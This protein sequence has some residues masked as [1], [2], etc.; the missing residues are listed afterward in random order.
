M[1]EKRMKA[2]FTLLGL[3]LVATAYWFGPA[4]TFETFA[5]SIATLLGALNGADAINTAFFKPNGNSNH[6]EIPKG[7]KVDVPEFD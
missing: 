2:K 7:G 1:F 6:F 4:A 5:W 3:A